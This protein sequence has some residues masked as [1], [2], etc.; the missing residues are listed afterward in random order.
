MQTAIWILNGTIYN[1][2]FFSKPFIRLPPRSSVIHLAFWEFLHTK[3]LQQYCQRLPS[4]I[5]SIWKWQ[6]SWADSAGEIALSIQS[7]TCLCGKP[8]V[9]RKCK[10]KP[11]SG[12]CNC[13]LD[14]LG[15]KMATPETSLDTPLKTRPQVFH[16]ESLQTTPVTF[17]WH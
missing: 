16:F 13:S 5:R 17:S 12:K 4:P 1:K 15:T 3:A 11:L 10:F 14:A 9:E 2:P 8:Q 7:N 6:H